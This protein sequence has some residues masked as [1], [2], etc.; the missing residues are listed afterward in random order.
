ML[1]KA[2]LLDEAQKQ[3]QALSVMGR[4]RSWLFVLTTCFAV[5]AASGLRQSGLWFALG[6]TCAVLTVLCFLAALIVNLS[7]RNGRRNVE[8]LLEALQ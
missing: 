8:R 5:L 6:V 7:I 4:W 2:Q 3:K 1:T